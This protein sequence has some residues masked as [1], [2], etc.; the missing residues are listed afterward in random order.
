MP[1]DTAPYTPD[2]DNAAIVVVAID[3]VMVV[4]LAVVVAGTVEPEGP[5]VVRVTVV[6]PTDVVVWIDELRAVL[7]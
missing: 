5:I 2:L 1:L 4:G 3:P 7:L 6:V